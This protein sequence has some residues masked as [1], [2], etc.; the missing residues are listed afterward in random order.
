LPNVEEAL[1][2]AKA[3]ALTE[4]PYIISFVIDK[5]GLILDGTSLVD[6]IKYIDSNTNNNPF[7]Y[8]VNCAFPSFL[9]ADHQPKELFSRLIGYQANASSLD[10][11]DLE[12]A[13]QLKMNDISEWGDLMLELNSKYGVEILGGCCGT[14]EKHLKYLAKNN[15]A[16]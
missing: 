16:S 5:N 12:C 11:C 13:E 8:M 10:H 2:I 3:M 15:N 14:N 6:A 7:G 9:N 4:V 1:G